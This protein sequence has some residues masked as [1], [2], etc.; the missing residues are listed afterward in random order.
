MGC[1]A[2]TK[3]KAFLDRD[4]YQCVVC[5]RGKKEGVEL[6]VDH[7]KPKSLGGKADIFNGQT[8]CAQ[9]NFLKKNFKQTE[10]GKKMFIRLFEL[11]KSQG[12]LEMQHF[13]REIL[14]VFERNGI[15]GHIEWKP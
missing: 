5:G 15:N 8:L 10:A 13:C 7:I 12:D 2:A 1:A 14:E 6:H 3:A 4:G 9:H 11:A